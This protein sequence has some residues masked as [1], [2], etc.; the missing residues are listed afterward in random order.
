MKS[1]K[2]NPSQGSDGVLQFHEKYA[3]FATKYPPEN[4]YSRL[5]LLQNFKERCLFVNR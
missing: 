3:P 5:F 1:Q 2:K 4:S